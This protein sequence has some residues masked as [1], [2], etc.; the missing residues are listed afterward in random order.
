MIIDFWINPTD[1]KLYSL[2]YL[3]SSMFYLQE[4]PEGAPERASISFESESEENDEFNMIKV[5]N[6]MALLPD[7]TYEDRFMH[8]GEI[9]TETLHFNFF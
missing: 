6:E 2:E 3:D 1:K 8:I 5:R 7:V 4:S 9:K